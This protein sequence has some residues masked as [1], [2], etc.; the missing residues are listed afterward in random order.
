MNMNKNIFCILTLLFSLFS[1]SS[2]EKDEI[3]GTATEKMAGEW[4]VTADAIDANGKVVYEDVFSLGRF[5]L[6]TYNLSSNS[7]DSMWIDDHKHFWEF[8]SKIKVDMNA[9]TFETIKS[10]NTLSGATVAIKNGKILLG[11]ATTPSGSKADSIVFTV[12]FSDDTYPGSYGFT[13]YRVSGFRYT[14]LKNDD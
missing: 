2:C 4:Y 6:D 12:N 11:A 7:T 10:T 9:M 3:G 13:S 8:K 14:G 5:H 1:F